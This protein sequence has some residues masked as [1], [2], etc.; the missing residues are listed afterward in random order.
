MF[1]YL[2]YWKVYKVNAVKKIALTKIRCALK[3]EIQKAGKTSPTMKPRLSNIQW[4]RNLPRKGLSYQK[5]ERQLLIHTTDIGE[6]IFIQY[7]GKESRKFIKNG[8]TR[9]RTAIRP[10]DFRPILYTSRNDDRHE[11]M[12]FGMMWAT[13]FETADRIRGKNKKEILRTFGTLLYRMA[14]MLDHVKVETF[15]TVERDVKYRKSGK[16]N[17]SNGREKKLPMLFKYKPNKEVLNYIAEE[18]PRWGEMSLE[19]FL[20][21][22][23]LLVWNEDCKYYY[24]NYH[25][26]KDAKWIGSTGRVNT[27]LSHIRIFGYMLGDVPLSDIFDGFARQRGMSPASNDE[28]IQICRGFIK[29]V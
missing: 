2:N 18:C 5:K 22:N 13:I 14:F 24:R 20:F 8:K 12:S 21:Y 11:D 1:P 4:I 15:K 7:P 17:Y 16:I 25:V 10:W 23:E 27:L 9:K 26:R 29:A 3:T 6:K 28:V 19:G